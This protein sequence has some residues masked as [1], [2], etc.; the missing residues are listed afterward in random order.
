MEQILEYLIAT[1]E[2]MNATQGWRLAKMYA[3][4]EKM[5]AWQKEMTVCQKVTEA[6]LESKEP[7]S[8]EIESVVVQE[9]VP[10]EV[11]TMK[12]VRALKEQYEDQHLA[13]G[14]CRQLKK[15]NQAVVYPGRSWLPP[16]EG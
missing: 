1:I 13:V 4:L 7:T 10:K 5:K 2:K 9:E 3:W 6:C 14:H 11:A 8:V 12:T 15:W 16:A